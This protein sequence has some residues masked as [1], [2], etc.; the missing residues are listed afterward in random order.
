MLSM[1]IALNYRQNWLKN[2]SFEKWHKYVIYR[3]N[4]FRIWSKS[5]RLVEIELNIQD[6]HNAYW[7]TELNDQYGHSIYWTTELDDQYGQST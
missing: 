1:G 7:T 4:G 3:V 2:Y 5:L 6:M